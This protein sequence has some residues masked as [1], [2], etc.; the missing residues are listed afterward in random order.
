MEQRFKIYF[1]SDTHGHI[2][3]V[4]YAANR[5]E[6]SGLLN[7]YGKNEQDPQKMAS[8][9]SW[10]STEMKMMF[11]DDNN[12]IAK[13]M[14]NGCNMG[15]Q[16]LGGYINQYKNASGPSMNLAKDI[17]RTEETLMKDVQKFL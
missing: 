16:T 1:T 15:I 4:N 8:A 10:L 13:I 7:K 2:F 6:A 14:M 11:K 5:P 3:P 9:F 17:V 12:Q